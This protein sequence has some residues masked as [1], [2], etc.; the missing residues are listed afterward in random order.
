MINRI[1]NNDEFIQYCNNN[2]I[3]YDKLIKMP[4][5]FSKNII[6]F[7]V[8]DR[9]RGELG[10]MDNKPAKVILKVEFKDGHFE[11]EAS[12]DILTYVGI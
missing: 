12:D 2:K 8:I 4:R 10:L 3:D 9:E 5:C 6:L 7:Q 11:Y 1:I